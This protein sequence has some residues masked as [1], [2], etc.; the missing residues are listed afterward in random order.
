M[1]L[2]K[3]GSGAAYVTSC[4]WLAARWVDLVRIDGR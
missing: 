3:G 4:V 1:E 2:D